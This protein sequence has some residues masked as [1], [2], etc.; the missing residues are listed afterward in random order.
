M[1]K[2]LNTLYI[3][4]EGAWAHKE[5]ANV[6]V[7]LEGKERGRAPL[8]LLGAI[9]CFGQVGVSPQLMHACAEAGICITYLGWSGRFLARVEGPVSGNVLLRRVQHDRTLNDPLP[10]ARAM[11]AAKAANQRGVLRRAIRDYGDPDGR[12]DAAE[13]RLSDVARLALAAPDGDRLRGQEGEAANAYFSVFANLIRVKDM[14]FNGR[15]RRPPRDA[16]NALLSFLYV[17]LAADCRAALETVGL[18]PQ[19]GFLHRDRPG[20]ASLA[21]DLMEEFRAPLADRLCLSLIN[22]RQLGPRSFQHQETGGVVLTDEARKT[23]LT[24]WQERKRSPIEHV[25]LK[26]KLPFGLFP[27][28]QAQ[29][30]A[31]HLRGDLDGYPAFIWR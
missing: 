24:A 6:V 10:V 29:L 12:L 7:Q 21:L 15:S 3:T 5:G 30:L 20:R 13:R 19:M 17:L 2:L 1:K 26:E 11:V 28:V 25:F 18:D 8:H 23:V 16:A 4:S 14:L 22:R 27:H 9:I 31:R